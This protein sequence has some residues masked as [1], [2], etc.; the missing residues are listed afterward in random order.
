ME[1][2][3]QRD[4]LILSIKARRKHFV[5]K[6]KYARI[7][8]ERGYDAVASKLNNCEET[9]LLVCCNSCHAHWYVINHC[10]SRVCP[11]CSYKVSKERAN[12]IRTMSKQMKYPKM[13]TLTMPRWTRSGQEGIKYLR[14]CFNKFKRQRV[15]K[16]VVGGAYQIEVKI[17]PDGYHIHMHII[18][19]GPYVPYQ[20]IFT[21][22]SK[23]I[24]EDAPQIRVE[25]P[26]T[27]KAM[28]YV[29][30]Y[31]AKSADFDGD[32]N[33]IVEWY[34]ATKGQRL[35]TT[36]G[37]WYNVKIEAMLNPDEIFVPEN[38]C[39]FCASMGTAFFAR[40]GPH[41]FGGDVWRSMKIAFTDNEPELK[42]ILEV[43]EQL[44]APDATI[45]DNQEENSN[46]RE[47]VLL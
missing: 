21:A 47:E 15:F 36:F 25:S 5:R 8:R 14:D 12:Y 40:D 19:D 27:A 28:E 41:I 31:A 17:K 32:P 3:K 39:P 44:I 35:F 7:F 24:G 11:L 20:H 4:S 29:A 9:E 13:L 43:R 6:N 34:E 23:I 45:H 33:N 18:Y 38:K 46:E 37:K 1:T 16:K 26:K 30:K 2:T 10:R 22:W 42:N